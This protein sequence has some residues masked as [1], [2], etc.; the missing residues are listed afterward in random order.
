MQFANWD[1]QSTPWADSYMNLNCYYTFNT[2]GTTIITNSTTNTQ[3]VSCGSTEFN[4]LSSAS[5]SSF[6]G[7]RVENNYNCVGASINR[8][9]TN[10]D[11]SSKTGNTFTCSFSRNLD[12][13][14]LNNLKD[15]PSVWFSS[16]FNFFNSTISTSS[17]NHGSSGWLEF[18]IAD[19][20]LILSISAA[21]AAVL[22]LAF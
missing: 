7:N 21:S 4:S 22:S 3:L 5:M 19:S 15:L 8:N 13:Q 14:G 16:G 6:I 2:I 9:Y 10:A 17:T 1:L 11:I 20:A 18:K 12:A